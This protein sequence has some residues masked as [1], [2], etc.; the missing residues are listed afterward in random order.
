MSCAY[1]TYPIRPSGRSIGIIPMPAGAGP[2][3]DI[4]GYNQ[5]SAEF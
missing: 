4:K 3:P 1:R 5:I 2:G